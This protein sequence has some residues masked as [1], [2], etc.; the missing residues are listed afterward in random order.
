MILRARVFLRS[1]VRIASPEVVRVQTERNAAAEES[2]TMNINV[3]V[4]KDTP[5]LIVVIWSAKRLV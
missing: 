4:R 1:R 3:N 2:V 5:H